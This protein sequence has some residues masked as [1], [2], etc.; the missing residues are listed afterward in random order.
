[1]VAARKKRGKRL[2]FIVLLAEQAESDFFVIKF[3]QIWF[4]SGDK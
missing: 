1:M 4:C 3:L 2:Q